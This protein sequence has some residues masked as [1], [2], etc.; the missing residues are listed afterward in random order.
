M[1]KG[2]KDRENCQTTKIILAAWSQTTD[3]KSIYVTNSIL[4]AQFN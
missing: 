3:D 1:E 2:G 4:I